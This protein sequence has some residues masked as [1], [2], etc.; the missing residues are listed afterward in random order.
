MGVLPIQL[1]LSE[2]PNN[3]HRHISSG[4]GGFS[5]SHMC[6]WGS[7]RAH[8]TPFETRA[9]QRT[10]CT[11]IAETCTVEHHDGL[12]DSYKSKQDDYMTIRYSSARAIC[13]YTNVHAWIHYSL[14]PRARA[15]L[16]HIIS[17]QPHDCRLQ[18]IDI[19]KGTLL[20]LH[21][22]C[23]VKTLLNW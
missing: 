3:L 2:P 8:P 16:C 5:L 9:A 11:C 19:L 22:L 23:L 14:L 15:V 10:E 20:L 17:L 4:S 6:A 18:A 21:R 1:Q 12:S 13:G 7:S